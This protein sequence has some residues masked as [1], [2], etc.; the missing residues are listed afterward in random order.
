MT[1]SPECSCCQAHEQR[2]QWLHDKVLD[3]INVYRKILRMNAL[4]SLDTF[5]Q[6]EYKRRHSQHLIPSTTSIQSM[7]PE[8]LDRI[9]SYVQGENLLQ[10]CSSVPYYKYI[11]KAILNLR[12]DSATARSPRSA[13]ID[14]WEGIENVFGA[15][16]AILTVSTHHVYSWDELDTFLSLIKN[17]KKTVRELQLNFGNLQAAGHDTTSQTRAVKLLKSI[18]VRTLGIT[19]RVPV[20]IKQAVHL[21]PK[22]SYLELSSPED[23]NGILLSQCMH[24]QEIVVENLYS[25]NALLW[26]TPML[27]LLDA[28]KESRVRKLTLLNWMIHGQLT[29]LEGISLFF[30]QQGWHVQS[31]AGHTVTFVF[32][33]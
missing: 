8:V 25:S 4:K 3:E 13:R 14:N 7:P 33:E 20:K 32:K 18:P 19:A 16:P 15:L 24:L 31:A 5:S 30:L 22:L 1:C 6:R 21:F 2:I 28:V 12:F 17:S 26:K 9:A 10:L 29:R 23:C 27:Q 11:S